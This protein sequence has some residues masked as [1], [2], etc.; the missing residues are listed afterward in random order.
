[1]AFRERNCSA[2]RF[3]RNQL[4]KSRPGVACLNFSASVMMCKRARACRP[5][6]VT[7]VKCRNAWICLLAVMNQRCETK[8][9]PRENNSLSSFEDEGLFLFLMKK[10][11]VVKT[12]KTIVY[13]NAD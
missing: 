4:A 9:V 5:A 7:C 10:F 3:R 8:V 1:M 11:L 12:A 13:G 6:A 2:E